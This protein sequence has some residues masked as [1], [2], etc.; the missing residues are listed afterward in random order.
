VWF[1][2]WTGLI[3]GWLVGVFFGLRWLWRQFK[4]LMEAFGAASELATTRLAPAATPSPIPEVAIFASA[5]DLATRFSAR[6][7]RIGAR[8][9]RRRERH[10]AAY[11]RWA[12]LAGYAE[13]EK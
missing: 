7:E 10:Q 1:W 11:D 8:R 13:A 3:L 5:E 9:R 4:E 2:I 6:A 12:V